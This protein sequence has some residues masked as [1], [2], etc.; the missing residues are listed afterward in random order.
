[1]LH[2]PVVHP[3]YILIY[4]HFELTFHGANSVAKQLDCTMSITSTQSY[5]IHSIYFSLYMT[6]N[7]DNYSGTKPIPGWLI[8]W[9]TDRPTAELSYHTW[10]IPWKNLCPKHVFKLVINNWNLN[11]SDILEMLYYMDNPECIM[12]LFTHLPFLTHQ[13][14]LLEY[15]P[16]S[17][18]CWIY[19]TM[20]AD[21]YLWNA[22]R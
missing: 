15:F 12:F 5:G 8:I 18:G 2:K 17:E 1:M 11:G 7:V 14:Y 9:V 22:H 19:S 21:D 6:F 3:R 10:R 16:D 13:D 20:N 4:R